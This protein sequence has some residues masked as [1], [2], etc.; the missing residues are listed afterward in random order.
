MCKAQLLEANKANKQTA[1][2]AQ[3]K[4][5]V[6]DEIIPIKF[7]Q[8][9]SIKL[10]YNKYKYTVD[11]LSRVYAESSKKLEDLIK[12]KKVDIQVI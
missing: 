11:S 6:L 5:L 1:D 2:P 9:S 12:D 7:K 3:Q 4:S 10:D 8:D